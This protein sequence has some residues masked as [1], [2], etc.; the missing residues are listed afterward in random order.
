MGFTT[1]MQPIVGYNYG[2]KQFDRVRSAIKYSVIFVIIFAGFLQLTIFLAP[3]F[4]MNLFIKDPMIL[5]EGIFLIKVFFLVLVL[6]AVEIIFTRYFQ[7]ISKVKLSMVFLLIAQF[8][9]AIPSML[10]VSH[11]FGIYGVFY[12]IPVS[13]VMT[14]LVIT[15]LYFFTIKKDLKVNA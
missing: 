15:G 10:I 7:S 14:F 5:K 8:G 12:S 1:G 11:M 4:L 13:N 3:K 9:I 6:R 2:A